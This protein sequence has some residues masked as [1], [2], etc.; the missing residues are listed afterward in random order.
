MDKIEYT[1]STPSPTP[2]GAEICVRLTEEDDSI[3]VEYN[4]DGE[5]AR[6]TKEG[7]MPKDEL[8]KLVRGF[9]EPG[10]KVAVVDSVLD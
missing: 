9:T 7:T 8:F 3:V 2:T 6:W 5:G 4:W 10:K 1:T